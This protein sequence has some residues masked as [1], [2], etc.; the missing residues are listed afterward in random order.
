MNHILVLKLLSCG[1]LK[2]FVAFTLLISQAQAQNITLSGYV[3]ESG[4]GE[5]LIGANLVDLATQQGATTNEYGF[6]SLTLPIDSGHLVVSY[7]GYQRDTIAWT[8][9]EDVN[10]DVRLRRAIQL[11]TVE[12]QAERVRRIEDESQMSRNEIPVEQIEKLPA[13]LGETDVLKTLQLMPGVQSGSEGTSGIYVRAG[14]IDQNLILVDGVPIYNPTHVLGIFSSFNSDAIKSVS[15]T[16]GG[17]PARYG[18][19]LS[20]VVEVNMRDGHLNEFHGSGQIGLISSKLLLEGPIVREK[21]SFLVSIRRSY[22]DIIGRPIA[23]IAQKEKKE[24][25]L[26]TA[27]FHDINLKANHRFNDQHRLVFSGYYGADRYGAKYTD[28]TNHTNAHVEWGNYLGSLNWNHRIAPKLFANTTVTYS[29]YRLNNDI[30]YTDSDGENSESFNSLYFS[31]IEDVGLKYAVDYAPD[32]RHFLKMGLGM[33]HHTYSPGALTYRYDF[34]TEKDHREFNQ[35]HLSSFEGAI[36]VE[37]DMEFGALRMNAGLHYSTFLTEGEFYHSLQPR[38]STRYKFPGDWSL[39]ASYASMSQY[40]NLLTSEALSLPTDLWVPSTGRIPPQSSWQVAIG[41]AKTLWK[42]YE[43]SIE[44]YYKEM[45]NVLS[46]KPGVS[47]IIDPVS[48]TDWQEKITQGRGTSYGAEFL[49]QKKFGRTTGWLAYTLSW[50][51]RQFD[52]INRGEVFPYKYD[53]RHDISIVLAH[54]LSDRWSFSGAWIYGTGNAYSIPD[55]NFPMITGLFEGS[56]NYSVYSE[57]NNYRMSDYHR[58]DVSFKRSKKKKWG[59]T[60]WT[61][62]A[63]NA[64]SRMN[65]FFVME[66]DGLFGRGL[67]EVA[68][69]PVIP[70]FSWGFKF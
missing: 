36:F 15:I 51:T 21:S 1:N 8:A 59:T 31:G 23:R 3:E 64:Y 55:A 47:F 14:S 42:D 62:G 28:P 69:L 6:Y 19:R 18:G 45:E 17:F 39:K 40:L 61:F 49:F 29:R 27:F 57:K 10:I 44:G 33:T 43:L 68:I 20:S 48:S 56:N 25:V 32:N 65:P 35:D 2:Y 24:K 70:Y 30:T 46:Y 5:K 50:N 9:E 13:F 37:D 41:G 16:K 34:G 12:I 58:L 67:Q 53:R 38:F 60:S 11:E 7:V 52:V 22:I 66:G 63:Y 54:D 4:S 26:P